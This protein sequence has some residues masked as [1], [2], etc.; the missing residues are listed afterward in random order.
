MAIELA[1]DRVNRDFRER[2]ESFGLTQAQCA[3]WLG[4]TREAL[5]RVERGQQG[6]G[7]LAVAY[8]FMLG[9][10]D[11]AAARSTAKTF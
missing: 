10:W 2:R 8:G 1:Q 3:Q 6:D 9:A 5:G 7:M 11:P 4:C